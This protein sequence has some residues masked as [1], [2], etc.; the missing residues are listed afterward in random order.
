M[1][2][3]IASDLLDLPSYPTDVQDGVWP[4]DA[5]G[6]MYTMQMVCEVHT[7]YSY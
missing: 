4:H 6:E 2:E 1:S 3:S 5:L 7:V